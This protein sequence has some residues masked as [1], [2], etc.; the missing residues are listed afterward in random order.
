MDDKQQQLD[1][2]RANI[3]ENNVCPE[4]AAQATN[5]V[6]GDGN[7]NAEIVFIGE[8]PGKNEDEQGVPFVGAAGK[9]L[10]EMLAAAG[11]ERSDVYI[12]NIVKYRPPNNR[13]P[14]PEEKK[15]FWPYLLKQLQIIQPKVVITLGRHS[16]EYFLPGM[17]ISQIHGQPKR[18]QFGDQK[19]VIIPLYHPAA[20]LYNGS[21]RQT[22]IDD[23]VNVPKIISMMNQGR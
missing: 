5:L 23:F 22:L 16:M 20:A 17:R 1:R 7:L 8:A 9:F 13:D 14:L 15:A 4:L 21:M 10:N 3:L 18:I 12:T 19:I 6:I 11:M 2:V